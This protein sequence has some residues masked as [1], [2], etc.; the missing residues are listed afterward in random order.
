MGMHN[1]DARNGM[2]ADEQ[3]GLR[4]SKNLAYFHK[5]HDEDEVRKPPFLI[6]DLQ[7]PRCLKSHLPLQLLPKELWTVKPKIIYVAREPKDVAVSFYHHFRFLGGYLGT[8]E[9]FVEAFLAGLVGCGLFW[10]HVLDFWNLRSEP[11]IF[12]T[13][14]EEMKKDLPGLVTKV[15]NFLNR[16]I[17]SEQLERLCQHL[18]F[19]SMKNNPTVS[20]E[21]E[22]RK[23]PKDHPE[24]KGKVEPFIR[25]GEIGSWKS[26]LSLELAEKID[27]WTRERLKDTD[28]PLSV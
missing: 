10:D 26:D 2:V 25:K 21:D 24:L 19:E 9:D 1:L 13:T 20:H 22:I 16:N 7:S 3:F 17:S 14:F 18:S 8:C 28:Y 5:H 6:K 4:N 11:N 23:R 27:N 12:F 15:A